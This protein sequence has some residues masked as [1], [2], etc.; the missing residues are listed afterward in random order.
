VIVTGKRMVSAIARRYGVD[1][2]RIAVVEPGTDRAPV[3]RGSGGP[4]VELLS[5]ATLN[6]GKGH[7]FLFRALAKVP[8]KNWHLTCAGSLERDPATAAR[9][10]AQLRDEGLE[11]K[12][13]LTGE[14]DWPALAACYDR[15][16]V[17][18]S[19]SLGE[20][21][22][23]AIAE[24]LARGLPVVGNPGALFDLVAGRPAGSTSA[25][26]H[27]AGLVVPPNRIELFCTTLAAVIG[28]KDLR[29]RLG[30]VARRVRDRLPTW[31][32]ASGR[33][34]AALEG[35]ATDE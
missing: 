31:E 34:A 15:A 3:A 2:A 4:V 30:S 25:D 7:E 35:V 18:V 16:D 23:M 10:R 27:L 9:L 26:N 12:V 19:A 14:L 22:G 20:T 17:F 5:V 24:A 8:Q 28:D 32:D 6:A 29:E 1:E 11:D 13:T 21:Y 33:M